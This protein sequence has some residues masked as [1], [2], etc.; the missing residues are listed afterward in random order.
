[1]SKSTLFTEEKANDEA[2]ELF[3]EVCEDISDENTDITKN[4]DNANTS[5]QK[6]PIHKIN[7]KAIAIIFSVL[8]VICILSSVS[9][10]AYFKCQDT[11]I[12]EAGQAPDYSVFENNLLLSLLTKVDLKDID[13]TKVH[14]TK[15]PIKFLGFIELESELEFKDTTPPSF[16]AYDVYISKGTPFETEMAVRNIKDSTK[17]TLKFLTKN[18]STQ[19][20]G[21]FPIQFEILDEHGNV[22][23]ITKKLVVIDT[24][25]SLYFEKGKT[26]GD[27]KERLSSLYPDVVSFDYKNSKLL[28]D[29]VVFGNNKKNQYVLN[30][31]MGD[32]VAP[33]ATVKSFDIILGETVSDDMIVSNVVDRSDVKMEILNRPSFDQVGEHKLDVILTDFY[34]NSSQHQSIIRIH[35]IN[36]NIYAELGAKAEDISPQV[37]NDDFSKNT[38]KIVDIP[39]KLGEGKLRLS[40]EFNN[41]TINANM[42]DTISPDLVV[43]NRSMVPNSSVSYSDFI[44]SCNDP[45]PVTYSLS[46][47]YF[48]DTLGTYFLTVTATDSCGNSTSLDVELT[49]LID[50][51]P[52][53]FFGIKDRLYIIGEDKADFMSEIYADDEVWGETDI[54]LDSSSVDLQ[55]PGTYT[56]SYTATDKSGN[57]ATETATVTVKYPTRVKVEV[58]NIL[59]KP[60]LPNGCEV[61][62][63]AIV[64]KYLGHP[65]EPFDLY[66]TYM[67]QTPLRAGDPWTSYVGDATGIGYGC[68][69]PC[70]VQ[71]GNDYLASIESDK[72]VYD[73]SG[74]DLSEYE[75][76]IDEGTPVIFWG[77]IEMNCDDKLAWSGYIRRKYV[78]WHSYSHCLVLIGYSDHNFIFCDPLRG[79]VEYNRESV[80]T[81][82]NINYRQA[83]IIK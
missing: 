80:E 3:V 65:I 51:K 53:E 79:I 68:Y 71:T 78:D 52:P 2:I 81:S 69:A 12:G 83:C 35:D 60:E 27:V 49:I 75:K 63:L 28:G 19:E 58:E 15:V 70:V 20:V 16:E 34:G 32:T 4:N 55:T 61:V 77:L 45:S 38:L 17:T 14:K 56:I 24:E 50:T 6:K 66:E 7:K 47:D 21:E 30:I 18:I 26:V 37:F 40:G 11:V 67:P 29:Y 9:V 48:T 57:T 54:I 43:R 10:W 5:F 22:V 33:T 41:I 13:H 74:L 8:L 59:Q 76:Y 42:I 36:S 62:S 1:M 44:V 73:V 72:T 82:F 31:I 64:L 25:N 39:T 46:G 23:K